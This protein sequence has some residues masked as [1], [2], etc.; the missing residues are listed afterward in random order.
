M[1]PIKCAGSFS[2][3]LGNISAKKKKKKKKKKPK[4]KKKKKKKK[5]SAKDSI[6]T[7]VYYVGNGCGIPQHFAKGN[8]L[9]F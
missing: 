5:K 1:S 4:N 2:V 8:N 7:S 6:K 3:Y 9:I